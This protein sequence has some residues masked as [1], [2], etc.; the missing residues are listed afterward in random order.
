MKKII[1]DLIENPFDIIY[2]LFFY[3]IFYFSSDFISLTYS[4]IN[5]PDFAKYYR[6]FEF[7]S[8]NIENLN[9]EQG[10]F[11]FFINYLVVLIFSNSMEYLT[12]Y[13]IVNFSVH[14][15]NSLIFFSWLLRDEEVSIKIF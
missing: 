5:S 4:V 10:H 11:Y 9:L 14:F 12:L 7:Y 3:F 13:E 1:V 15:G 2:R 6:Y 8:G